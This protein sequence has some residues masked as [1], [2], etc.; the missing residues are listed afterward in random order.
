[1]ADRRRRKLTSNP[2]AEISALLEDVNGMQARPRRFVP[3]IGA[4]AEFSAS[5]S[6][7]SW[8][9]LTED[10]D[11]KVRRPHRRARGRDPTWPKRRNQAKSEFLANMSHEI[12]T[13]AQRH[14]R[15]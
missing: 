6:T 9:A 11:R 7:P 15:P 5:A 1:M 12:R 4:G 3:A 2:P 13:P 14:H 10:L 8:R